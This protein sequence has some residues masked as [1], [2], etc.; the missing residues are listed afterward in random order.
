[1]GFMFL[2][3]TSLADSLAAGDTVVEKWLPVMEL[4]VPDFCVIRCETAEDAGLTSLRDGEG[5]V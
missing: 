5:R 4:A 1:M 2:L 3:G